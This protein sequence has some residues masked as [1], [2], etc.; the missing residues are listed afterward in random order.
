MKFYKY[1][2]AI[3]K[4]KVEKTG[5]FGN[6]NKLV[7]I[8]KLV[9]RRKSKENDKLNLAL[10]PISVKKEKEMYTTLSQKISLIDYKDFKNFNRLTNSGS[11]V[12]TSIHNC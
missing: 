6:K 11:T 3:S 10:R 9:L 7:V 12:N 8:E 4:T 1:K 5:S 2:K